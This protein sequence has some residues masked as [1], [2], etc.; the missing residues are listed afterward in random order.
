MTEEYKERIEILYLSLYDKLMVYAR[1]AFQNEGLA[2]EAIQD[3]FR[4]ACMKPQEVCESSNPEGWIVNTLKHIIA[5]TKRNR[6]TA[7]RILTEYISIQVKELAVSED[8]LEFSLM[9]EDVAE[10]EEY[11]LIR[12]MIFE[13]KSHLELARERGISVA[14]CRKRVQRAKEILRKKILD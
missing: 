12:E 6:M 5:N 9:Y 4:I 13:G 10:L 11:R 1:C 2:E 3:T 8:Q 7:N 14:A